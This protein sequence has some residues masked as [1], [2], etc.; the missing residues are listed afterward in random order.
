MLKL[1]L[2]AT[3]KQKDFLMA[4]PYFVVLEGGE[5]SGKSTQ[6]KLLVEWLNNQGHDTIGV[7]DPGG[8]KGAEEIRQLVV[9]GAVDRWDKITEVL[10][11]SAAR[12]E[13]L[14]RQ[15]QPA[16]AGGQWVVS[17]RFVDSTYAYQGY[18]HGVSLD[19]LRQL[20]D[21]VVSD[22]TPDLVLV[23]DID[24]KI[25]L[26]RAL[27]GKNRATHEIR[28]ESMTLDF[29]QRLRHGYME[30]AAA[31]PVKHVVINANQSIED[32]HKA[33]IDTISERLLNV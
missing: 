3:D 12:R 19:T 23:L 7:R 29:H 26:Q 17:D 9:T 15:I 4:R 2:P 30:L 16:L 31:D 18:G 5:G 24:P 25:G 33:I 28:F 32:L 20:S 27:H 10:L 22:T 21:V 14:A 1:L 13:L 11:Y 6:I 8:P